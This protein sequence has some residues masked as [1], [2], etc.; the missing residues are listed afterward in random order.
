MPEFLRSH[1]A[2]LLS[3]F[4]ILQIG[5]FY[6]Y[7]KTE[8]VPQSRP[9]KQ[10]PPTIASWQMIEESEL[11]SEV[12]ALLKADDTL[13]RV[14]GSQTEQRYASLYIAY[15]RTQRTGVSPHSPKVCLPGSGWVPSESERIEIP[16][17]GESEPLL[18]N[19]YIVSKGEQKSTVLYWY[20]T[21][22][23]SIASEYAAKVYTVLD[24]VRYRRSDTSLVRVVVPHT[25]T[26]DT[27]ADAIAT[28][29]VQDTF[30]TLRPHLP[31]E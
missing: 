29:F 27:K 13:N 23:R 22:H 15:F 26:S 30:A 9:L 25:S 28:R 6:A 16:V 4:L 20:Q 31:N 12:A 19:R 2:K 18:V 17:P 7:P 8:V 21:A 14:Y 11:D 5:V 3:I 1:Y 24:S 10:V